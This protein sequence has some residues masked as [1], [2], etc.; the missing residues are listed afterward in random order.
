MSDTSQWFRTLLE[1]E[2]L[3]TFSEDSMQMSKGISFRDTIWFRRRGI[4]Y[5]IVDLKA[6]GIT[7]TVPEIEQAIV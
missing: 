6:S 3:L 1:Q 7:K 2:L 5:H 4:T